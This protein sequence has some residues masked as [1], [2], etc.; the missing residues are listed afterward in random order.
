MFKTQYKSKNAYE[1]W[2]TV[3]S[4]GREVEAIS[5]ALHK[6]LKGAVMVRVVN[7]KGAVI[8]SS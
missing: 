3:G 7:S 4:Y 8:Y 5:S 6:K 1:A 2:A